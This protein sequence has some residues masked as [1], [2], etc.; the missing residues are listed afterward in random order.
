[1]TGLKACHC[2]SLH[3]APTTNAGRWAYL[4]HLRG[5]AWNTQK[6]GDE[7]LKT[8]ENEVHWAKQGLDH[9]YLWHQVIRFLHHCWPSSQL[10]CPQWPAVTMPPPQSRLAEHSQ[11]PV[12]SD[13]QGQQWAHGHYVHISPVTSFLLGHWFFR[14]WGN[15]SQP[16]QALSRPCLDGWGEI[17][18]SRDETEQPYVR[19]I[20]EL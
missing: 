4:L 10:S 7:I 14:V 3:S 9:R 8:S 13:S 11:M 12:G 6:P 20:I 15:T 19:C 18:I 16:L 1:M 17:Q 5:L 2:V